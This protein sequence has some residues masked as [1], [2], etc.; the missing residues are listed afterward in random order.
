[1]LLSL[2][3]ILHDDLSAILSNL[4]STVQHKHILYRSNILK[5]KWENGSLHIMRLWMPM[6]NITLKSNTCNH[7]AYSKSPCLH[8][9]P[10]NHTH[11]FF[12]ANGPKWKCWVFIGVK[13]PITFKELSNP[14]RSYL[15]LICELN[16]SLYTL[17]NINFP[18]THFY[19]T[20]I[21]NY[22]KDMLC[23][24]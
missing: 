14:H 17:V 21:W 7:L 9:K 6:L 12:L 10:L 5:P 16:H 20:T 22:A 19:Q 13:D 1:M 15:F 4:N 2:R 18:Y 3:H 24:I 8:F 11:I 23:V